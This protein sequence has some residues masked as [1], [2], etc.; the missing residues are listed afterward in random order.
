MDLVSGRRGW[1]RTSFRQLS[2]ANDEG[3]GRQSPFC[4]WRF[5]QTPSNCWRKDL[6]I[7]SLT[8]RHSDIDGVRSM[9]ANPGHVA[10][11]PF[12]SYNYHGKEISRR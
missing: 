4:A 2:Q 10:T 11:S 8:D 9:A 6:P 3:L 5:Y 1:D 7:T 12:T